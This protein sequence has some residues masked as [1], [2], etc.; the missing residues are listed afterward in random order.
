MNLIIFGLVI[1]FFAAVA[2]VVFQNFN[3]AATGIIGADLPTTLLASYV[4]SLLVVAICEFVGG[5]LMVIFNAVRGVPVA[6]FVRITKVKSSRTI[7]I[8]SILGGPIATAAVMMAVA[9]CGS[10]YANCMLGLAPIVSA[11][12]GVMFLKEKSGIRVWIG[13][14]ISVTGAVIAALAPPEGVE[15]F[16]VGIAL[17]LV[18]PIAYGVE[19]IIS[20]HA[21]DTTDPMVAGPL[22]RMLASSCMEFIVVIGV[23]IA[24]G[25]LSW[26]STTFEIIVSSPLCLFFI[27]MTAVFMS[28]Q[29]NGTYAAYTYCGAIKA[30]AILFTSTIWTVPVGFAFSGMHILDYSVTA[31]GI[32][33]AIIVVVGIMVVVAKPSELLS[34][35][36]G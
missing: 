10:T 22:Y 31:L 4:M 33:G 6:E 36:W 12:L 35:T 16:Y 19:S 7:I 15:N 29:Y 14:A 17:A 25:H 13:I 1:A 30:T 23:C 18:A 21:V 32:V 24:M 34:V 3:V 5:I 27:L 26:I 9:L 11:I 8:S 28:I 20:A 2:N